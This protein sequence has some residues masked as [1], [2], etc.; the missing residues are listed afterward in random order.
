[1][2]DEPSFQELMSAI[3]SAEL[4]LLRAMRSGC[5]RDVRAEMTAC[6]HAIDAL[7]R[8]LFPADDDE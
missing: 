2:D 4:T 6:L 7:L 5:Y 8:G 3:L 1:M